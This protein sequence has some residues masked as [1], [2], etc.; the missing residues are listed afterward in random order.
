MAKA[1]RV[2]LIYRTFW[3]SPAPLTRRLLVYKAAVRTALLSGLDAQVLAR[4]YVDRLES[5]EMSRLRA[6]LR[7]G[8]RGQ[9]NA[10]V[11]EYCR[12]ASV[13]STLRKRRF[14]WLQ[15]I[16]KN[17]GHH[18]ALLSAMTGELDDKHCQLN[19]GHIA[20]SANPWLRQF[21]KDVEAA[22]SL[23]TVLARTW[24]SS[25]WRGLPS[26][27]AF[28]AIN[29]ARLL[30]YDSG[31]LFTRHRLDL[32]VCA[33]A[34]EKGEPCGAMCHEAAGLAIQCLLKHRC[35][36]STFKMV[37]ANQCPCC[38]AAFSTRRHA[39][40]HVDRRWNDVCTKGARFKGPVIIPDLSCPFCAQELCSLMRLYQH[41]KNECHC[42]S[43]VPRADGDVTVPAAPSG[44]PFGRWTL[45]RRR[46]LLQAWR[47]RFALRRRKASKMASKKK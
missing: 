4:V 45:G 12:V 9:D 25:G 32:R 26:S 1:R 24:R 2:W 28:S 35:R 23:D 29:S 34:D 41:M 27:Y 37:V 44:S 43:L 15:S 19:N 11:R 21:G 33:R 40:I 10:R 31:G 3:T 16:M 7:G 13:A 46:R 8:A 38:F 30:V 18:V 42:N 36:Y 20:L 47:Q 39:R 22:A 5:W 6:L 17:P 14:A